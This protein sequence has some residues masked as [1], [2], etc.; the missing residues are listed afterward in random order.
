[1]IIY[2]ITNKLNGKVYIG[3]TKYTEIERFNSHIREA[4]KGCN[5]RLHQAIRKYGVDNFEVEKICK[6]SSKQS[7]KKAE[8]LFIKKF[9]SFDFS[10]GYNMTNGGDGVSNGVSE[11]W[12]G[13]NH[14]ESSKNIMKIK[15]IGN[16]N[17]K[18]R[19]NF[20]KVNLLDLDGKILKT[21]KSIKE[22]ADDLE[23]KCPSDISAF[24]RG[25]K[26][27]FQKGYIFRYSGRRYKSKNDENII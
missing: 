19:T 7:M 12:K 4:L 15:M 24:C 21:F 10:K 23:I 9:N 26:K 1:M 11:Y 8:I 16:D 13:K 22:A 3:L 18:F 25:Y 27:S 14:K 20:V 17:A 5:Y 2:K 6:C